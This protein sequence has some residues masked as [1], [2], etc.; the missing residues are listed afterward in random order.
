[1]NINLGDILS[2]A[3]KRMDIANEADRAINEHY[4]RKSP[5]TEARENNRRI[6]NELD[7]MGVDVSNIRG[8]I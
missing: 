6:V 4:S 5:E 7:K 1:M 3:S 2:A 8:H